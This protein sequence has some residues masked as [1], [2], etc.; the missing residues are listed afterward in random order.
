MHDDP[1]EASCEL[2]DL[3]QQLIKYFDNETKGVDNECKAT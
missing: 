2:Y 3:K 1:C